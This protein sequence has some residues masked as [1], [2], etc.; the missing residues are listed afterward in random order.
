MGEVSYAQGT[1]LSQTLL[2]GEMFSPV[3]N[4][5]YE[6]ESV[7]CQLI[8]TSIYFHFSHGFHFLLLCINKG[9]KSKCICR[10]VFNPPIPVCWLLF[11]KLFGP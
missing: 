4:Q 3:S 5:Q 2:P 6:R 9:W 7:E 11:L 10:F 1:L 8:N